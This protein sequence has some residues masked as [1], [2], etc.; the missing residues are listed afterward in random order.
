[1]PSPG[2]QHP[3]SFYHINRIKGVIYAKKIIKYI[4]L[5]INFLRNILFLDNSS[6]QDKI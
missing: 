1:M 4:Y 2:G 6:G 3:L 5:E